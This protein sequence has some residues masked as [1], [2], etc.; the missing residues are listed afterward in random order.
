V[1]DGKGLCPED[2][3]RLQARALS[4]VLG[5][6]GAGGEGAEVSA[7]ASATSKKLISKIGE[8]P[9]LSRIASKIGGEIQT[10]IDGLTAKLASG[11]M[12]PGI[13]TKHLFGSIFE[14]RAR[15][16]ARVYFRN[17]GEHGLEIL[18][19]S[20][21]DTQAQVIRILQQLY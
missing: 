16:G 21:K 9:A 18:A 2:I 19:K 6:L 3:K 4:Y 8:S 14:A 5:S 7:L 10:S 20:T 1:D 12:N 11:N 13:G 15:D 17:A